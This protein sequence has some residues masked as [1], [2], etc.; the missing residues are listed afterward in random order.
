[1][2]DIGKWGKAKGVLINMVGEIHGPWLVL[3]QTLSYM[4]HTR[5]CVECRNCGF[6]PKPMTRSNLL[7]AGRHNL[8]QDCCFKCRNRKVSH[9]TNMG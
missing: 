3:K 9:E 4:Q 7:R 1:M 8:N 5:W 2:R 6:Q